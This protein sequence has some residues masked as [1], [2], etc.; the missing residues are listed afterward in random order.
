MADELYDDEFHV[1]FP[2][3]LLVRND[4][5][6][7]IDDGTTVG[8]PPRTPRAQY[9]GEFDLVVSGNW[10]AIFHGVRCSVHISPSQDAE[11]A[12][13]TGREPGEKTIS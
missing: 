13:K 4:C 11:V 2:S 10:P 8:E 12:G 6:Q 1:P 5:V 9:S 3:W 7:N